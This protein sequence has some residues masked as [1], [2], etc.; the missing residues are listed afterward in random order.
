M[1]TVLRILNVMFVI[2]TRDHGF[3]HVTVYLGSPESHEAMVKIR[4]DI[5][6][7]IENKGF[8]ESAVAR[9]VKTT[10]LH[11]GEWLEKWKEY[12]ESK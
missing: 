1:P 6:K 3:P 12:H 8:K 7:V 4:L 2:H 5:L 10:E 9:L 11:Q